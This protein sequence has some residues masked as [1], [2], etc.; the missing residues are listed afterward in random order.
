[1]EEKMTS[2]KFKEELSK[3]LHK[4]NEDQGHVGG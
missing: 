4:Y 2:D 3:L 1:M